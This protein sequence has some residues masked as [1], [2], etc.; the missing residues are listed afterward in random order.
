M[1]HPTWVRGLKLVLNLLFLVIATKSHPTWVRGLKPTNDNTIA[2]C[3][4]RTLRGCVD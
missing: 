1:S 2:L 4:S 3:Q